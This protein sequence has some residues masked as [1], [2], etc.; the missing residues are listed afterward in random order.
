MA[1][2]ANLDEA[3]KLDP[4][5]ESAPRVRKAR[6]E[7]AAGMAGRPGEAGGLEKPGP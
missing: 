1:C 7:I 5:G 4:E 3:A 2:K 6:E